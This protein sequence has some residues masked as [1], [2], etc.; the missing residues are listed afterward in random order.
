M[1]K[2][3]IIFFDFDNVSQN[4]NQVFINVHFNQQEI[5]SFDFVYCWICNIQTFTRLSFNLKLCFVQLWCIKLI[6]HFLNI[7]QIDIF[8]SDFIIWR[9]QIICIKVFLV[10]PILIIFNS[11]CWLIFWMFYFCII[12]IQFLHTIIFEYQWW[13]NHIDFVE[14]L[15]VKKKFC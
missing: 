12:I 7:I 4:N 3:K 6:I 2:Q 14:F 9:I 11:D 8:F 1:F 15:S 10:K 13:K 5:S